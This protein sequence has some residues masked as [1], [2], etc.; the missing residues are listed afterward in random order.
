MNKTQLNHFT[1]RANI[2]AAR[3]ENEIEEN[4]KIYKEMSQQEMAEEI[5]AGNARFKQ[6]EFLTPQC[7]FVR[8][9]SDVF[10]FEKENIRRQQTS[11]INSI[12]ID[13]RMRIRKYKEELI[14]NFVMMNQPDC[15]ELLK[16]FE[17]KDFL[18]Q[19]EKDKLDIIF[20]KR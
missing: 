1:T 11:V 17:G 19:E 5:I 12:M 15:P 18:T 3:K 20:K 2:I 14:D 13:V 9:L 16:E 4:Y 8:K 10:E 6:E 7:T